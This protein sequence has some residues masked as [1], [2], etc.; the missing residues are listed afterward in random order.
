MNLFSLPALARGLQDLQVMNTRRTLLIA[1]WLGLAP[2]L[3][4]QESALPPAELP[5]AAT[6]KLA[7]SLEAARPHTKHVWRDMPPSNADGTVNAYIEI[8]RGDRRKWELDMKRN[9]RAIDRMMPASLGGYPVN[10]G[11]VPQTISYD[12]DPFDALVLG[13]AIPGG[14]LVR[15]VVVGLMLMED[16]TGYDAK[17]VLSRT[18]SDGKPLHPLTTDDQKR[19]ADYFNRYKAHEPGKFSKVPG[20]GSPVAGM[21]HVTMTHTF[22][23]ECRTQTATPCR[24]RR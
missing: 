24:V 22:F 4:S 9:A 5:A 1:L 10:Y 19:M 17:V 21:A 16:E 2:G 6:Q 13:P 15:G 14:R 7:K 18:G 12:G 11:I 8:P 23:R 20:W 3:H